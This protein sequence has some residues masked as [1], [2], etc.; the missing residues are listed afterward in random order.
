[1]KTLF[2]AFALLTAATAGLAQADASEEAAKSGSQEAGKDDGKSERLIC[3]R[4]SD[5]D[6]GSLLQGRSRRC[7]TA[8]QWRALNRR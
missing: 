1:M 5:A 8:E 4:V 7:L 2:L 6:V 3:R